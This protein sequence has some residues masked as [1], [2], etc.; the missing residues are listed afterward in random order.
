MRTMLRTAVVLGVLVAGLTVC[1]RPTVAADAPSADK[2]FEQRIYITNPGK[3]AALH[4]RFREHTCQLFKNHGIELIGFW[5][6]TDGE[7]A[8]DTLIYL[9]AFPNAEAQKKAW[10]AFQDDP[11][12]KKAKA[13]SEKDG[14]LV[15]EVQS[16]NLKATDYSAI[17]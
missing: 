2:I 8:K 9:V 1:P 14:V 13:A 4:A 7:E 3:L 6:P 12:W 10:K 11:E 15:R 17:R 16:K 5:T